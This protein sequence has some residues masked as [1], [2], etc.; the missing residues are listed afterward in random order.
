MLVEEEYWD[1]SF[2][3]F[4]ADNGITCKSSSF[5]D[6]FYSRWE[7]E[8]IIVCP[9]CKN[10]GKHYWLKT[11]ERWKCR[12]CRKQ[13]SLKTGTCIENAKIPI[14]H[15]WRL[16][17]MLGT[18]V[19]VTSHFVSR[20]LGLSQKTSWYMLKTISTV[21][22]IEKFSSPFKVHHRQTQWYIM[23]KLMA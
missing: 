11:V 17:Y 18:G 4:F 15:W 1:N 20:D 19:M 14:T 8:I 16:A 2:N 23:K 12:E 10:I 5:W 3:E 13:F 22:G 6:F 9:F 21:L 7:D